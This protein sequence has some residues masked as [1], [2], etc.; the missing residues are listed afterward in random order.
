VSNISGIKGLMR[1]P[2]DKP[3]E[4]APP[5]GTGGP[6]LV[7]NPLTDQP[8]DKSQSVTGASP[9]RAPVDRRR[10][11][12]K[13]LTPPVLVTAALVFVLAEVALYTAVGPF[14]WAVTNVVVGVLLL[15]LAL[16]WRY[17]FPRRRGGRRGGGTASGGLLGGR[18]G[19]GTASGGLLGGRRGG[20]TASGGLLG[21]RRADVVGA[22]AA[23]ADV[24]VAVPPVAV[25]D[26][27]VAVPPVADVV[28]AVPPVALADL[29]DVVE[30]PPVADVVAVADCL[31]DVV[32]VPPERDVS[33][34]ILS[35]VSKRPIVKIGSDTR[36]RKAGGITLPTKLVIKVT[37]RKKWTKRLTT[38]RIPACNGGDAT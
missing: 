37:R 34:R 23:V 1:Q 30:V 31:A 21:G 20:G 29:A 27:V 19:G 6:P 4:N 35:L 26:V 9:K 33:S 2:L 3:L 13:I 12:E 14:W 25:A 8:L 17:L 5:S 36:M 22:V 11:W 15:L 28:V 32:A 38:A 10:P 24:V 7:I 18:R 16:V